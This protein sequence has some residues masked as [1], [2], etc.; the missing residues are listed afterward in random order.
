VDT[1]FLLL[2]VRRRGQAAGRAFLSPEL[3]VPPVL[4]LASQLS[5]GTTGCRYLR[6]DS[7][8]PHDAAEGA[9]EPAIFLAPERKQL[10]E[11]T[12]RPPE[13]AT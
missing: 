6:D 12:W 4:W 9:R 5:D 10:L 8:P 11:K 7:L 1:E 2:A 3:M 13:S